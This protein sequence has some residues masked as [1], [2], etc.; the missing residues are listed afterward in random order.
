GGRPLSEIARQPVF[1]VAVLSAA[2]GYG[3]MTLLM[4]ATPLAMSFCGY[5]YAA[6]A[7]VIAAHV[8]AMFAPSFVTGSIIQRIGVLPVIMMGLC[9][10]LACVGVALSGQQVM[11]FWWAL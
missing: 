11:N 6:S 3:V 8:V 7:G 10:E 1:I 5:P 9:L 4:T 2:L